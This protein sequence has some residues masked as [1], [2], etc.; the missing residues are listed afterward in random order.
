MIRRMIRRIRGQK[1]FDGGDSIALDFLFISK[2]SQPAH[3]RLA[4]KPCHL[5]LCV[6]SMSLLRSLQ[7]FVSRKLSAQELHC[8]A[9]AERR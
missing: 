4:S 2:P 3:F 8:L 9:I 6:V 5:P 1:F 7:G